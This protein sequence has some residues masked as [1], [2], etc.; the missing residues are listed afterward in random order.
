M[1]IYELQTNSLKQQQAEMTLSRS[2]HPRFAAAHLVVCMCIYVCM[3]SYI[4]IQW[5]LIVLLPQLMLFMECD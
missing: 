4:F 3:A 2:I 1:F 5:I